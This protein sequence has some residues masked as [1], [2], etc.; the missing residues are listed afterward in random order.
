[1]S[2]EAENKAKSLVDRFRQEIYKGI[3]TPA[4]LDL[5]REQARNER[6]KQCALIAVE[7]IIKAVR[8][9]V[10]RKNPSLIPKPIW[11]QYDFWKSVE[12][13]IKKKL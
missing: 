8:N 10:K 2:V 5:K 9:A 11:E 1:M 13:Q 12:E 7:E 6:A 4:N 3:L